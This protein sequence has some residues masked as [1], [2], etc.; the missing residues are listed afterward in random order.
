MQ[1]TIPKMK[2]DQCDKIIDESTSGWLRK[3]EGSYNGDKEHVVVNGE[4][5]EIG[6]FGDFCNIRCYVGFLTEQYNGLMKAAK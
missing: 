5:M 4:N 6:V 1:I 3:E 2:C